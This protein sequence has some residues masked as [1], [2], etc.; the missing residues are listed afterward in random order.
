MPTNKARPRIFY[1]YII[2]FVSLLI[3]IIMHGIQNTFSVF[4]APLQKELEANRATISSANSLASLVGGLAGIAM[5]R[6]TDRFGPKLVIAGSALLLGLGYFLMARVDSLW[7]LY[8]FYSVMGG[9][10][11]SSGN[12]ALLTTT[13]RWFIRR[14]GLMTG[15]VKVGTGAGQVIMPLVASMLITGYGWRDA[16]LILAFIGVFGIIP[17]SLFL[18]L[19]PR[20]MGLQPYGL[21]DIRATGSEYTARVQLS[22]GECVKTRQFWLVCAVYFLSGYATL[23]LTVHIVPYAMDNGIALVQTASIAS[24]IGGVSIAGRLVLGGAGDKMGNRLSLIICFIFI[25]LSLVWLQFAG[26]IGMLYLFAIIYGFGHGG[27]FA[28]MSPLVAELFGT[29][30]QG[31]NLGVVLFVQAVGA[32]FGPYVTG[33]I[34]D[35]TNS[36]RIAFLILIFVSLG[37]LALSLAITPVGGFRKPTT[38][39]ISGSVS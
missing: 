22:L 27:F 8:L 11:A 35:V 14:R 39:T 23:G 37:A 31:I 18:K 28:V 2:I 7:Q 10:G 5:G 3:L 29:A 15:V 12:V 24:V 30:H 34:F 25:T 17:L 16:C 13:T 21:N 38:G 1:G 19:D 33:Y 20:E 32:A 26:G 4:F 9:I 36:Y 6:L